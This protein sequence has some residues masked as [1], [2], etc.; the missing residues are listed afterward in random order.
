[1]PRSSAYPTL[2][3]LFDLACRDGVDI[4]PTLLRV[5]TDLYVQ[6]PV[7]SADEEAQ[8]V[9]LAGRLI[10]AVDAATRQTV[11][12]RLA[13]Y[14]AA[15][16]PILRALA[17]TGAPSPAQPR[18]AHTLQQPDLVELFFEASA[19][20]RR[21]ILLNLDVVAEAA[22]QRPNPAATDTVLRLEAAALQRS[23]ADF[24]RA[25]EQGLGISAQVAE[26]I[27]RDASGEPVVVAAKA[28]AMPAAVL[29][30][31]LLLLNPAV[32]RSVERVYTL[33]LLYDE[34]THGAAQHMLA[35]WR[36]T[37]AGRI[38]AH[39]PVHH[40]DERRSAR[41]AATPAEHRASRVRP[42]LAS[43]AHSNSR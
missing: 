28:L 37:G 14:A 4:R 29:Q 8:Y 20:E 39:A 38:A 7:H 3:G 36:Q 33:A 41:S 24:T 32:G 21:L 9:E 17:A 26:R 31:I 19:E 5:L 12:A 42:P 6:K 22:A 1:M 40:E 25:L 10:E 43:R 30:R 34:I 2:E 27:A 13:G 35:I 11:A 18:P 23:T 15:P 16:A